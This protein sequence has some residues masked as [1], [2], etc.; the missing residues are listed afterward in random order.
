M[1]GYYRLNILRGF[2]IC[3]LLLVGATAQL[4]VVTNFRNND[5]LFP[6]SILI[7]ISGKTHSF[8]L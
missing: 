7:H 3:T 1:H 5:V 2:T 6:F 4:V 8:P